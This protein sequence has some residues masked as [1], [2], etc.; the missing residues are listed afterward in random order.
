MTYSE[1]EKSLSYS[2]WKLINGECKTLFSLLL[3]MVSL[4]CKHKMI[5]RKHANY[6]PLCQNLNTGDK[7]TFL[8]LYY[9]YIVEEKCYE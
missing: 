3:I 9:R 5:Q 4:T 8:Q 2:V 6:E 1:A 7:L